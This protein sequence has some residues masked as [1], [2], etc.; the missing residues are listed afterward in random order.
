M[1]TIHQL[2][3]CRDLKEAGLNP[4]LIYSKGNPGMSAELPKYQ[5]PT[6]SYKYSPFDLTQVYRFTR[7]HS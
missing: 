3:R 4:N 2:I 1:S 5:A 7:M 6:V